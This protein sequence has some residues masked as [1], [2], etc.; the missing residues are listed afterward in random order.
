MTESWTGAPPGPDN[1]G[2]PEPGPRV[3]ARPSPKSSVTIAFT[4]ARLDA[5]QAARL[6]LTAAILEA[7]TG[8]SCQSYAPRGPGILVLRTDPDHAEAALEHALG[9]RLPNATELALA[10]SVALAHASTAVG[11]SRLRFGAPLGY[12]DAVRNTTAPQLLEFARS[13]LISSGLSIVVEAPEPAT[14]QSR[15][16]SILNERATK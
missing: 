13:T 5:A 11:L 1:L 6:D 2:R 15:V 14:A 9:F 16:L 10:Q 12:L 4:T 8:V 7:R 3:L